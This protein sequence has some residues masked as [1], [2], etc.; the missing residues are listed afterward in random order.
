MRMR[1]GTKISILMMGIVCGSLA[2][3]MIRYSG[4]PADWLSMARL[5]IGAA[6]VFPAWRRAARAH[7][8]AVG[9]ALRSAV[10]PGVMLGAHFLSWVWAVRLIPVAHST[11]IVNLAPV[12]MPFF[13]WLM[14]R[15]RVGRAEWAGVGLALAGMGVLWLADARGGSGHRFGYAVCLGSMVVLT[16]YLALGRRNRTLPSPWLFLVPMYLIAG[17]TCLPSAWLRGLPAGLVWRRE[18][19]LLLALGLLPTALGHSAILSAM[20]WFTAQTVSII[21][22]LQ[23]VFGGLWG[24]LFFREVPA[25]SFYPA[26]ALMVAGVM[27]AIHAAATRRR[28]AAPAA[29]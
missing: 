9:P 8:E 12:A 24:W 18:I 10:A 25:A 7:P 14:L 13:T 20:R 21:N 26:S 17:L 15:E 1:M 28:V 3:I 2:A 4:L 27:I 23:F 22:L 16:A 19:I 29:P 6:V 5:A 11:L